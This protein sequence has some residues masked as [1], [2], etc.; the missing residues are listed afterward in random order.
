MLLIAEQRSETRRRIEAGDTQPVDAAVVGDESGRVGIP[1]ERVLL[2]ARGHGAARLRGVAL[3][4]LLLDRHEGEAQLSER[5]AERLGVHPQPVAELLDQRGEGVD[6]QRRVV[7][8]GRLVTVRYEMED[9]ELPE[10]HGM[11]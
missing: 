11:V 4:A 8:A 9:R 2:D 1:D 3:D 7:E 5:V 10:A 6:G